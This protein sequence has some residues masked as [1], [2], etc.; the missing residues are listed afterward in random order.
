[1][2]WGGTL[3]R[4]TGMGWAWQWNITSTSQAVNPSGGG[5]APATRT[6]TAVVPVDMPTTETTGDTSILNWIYALQNASFSN[7]VTIASPVFAG[8]NLTLDNKATIS[9]AA[10]K[11]G[12]GGVL[13]MN[14]NADGVGSLLSRI[15]QAYIAGGCAWKGN[16]TPPP[17]HSPCLWDLDNVYA[18]PLHRGSTIPANLITTP[19]LTCCS[20]GGGGFAPSTMGFWYVNASPGPNSPCDAATKTGTPPTFDT[21]DGVINNSATL[22]TPF[23]L[24]PYNASYTCRTSDGQGHTIG[25]LS[26]NA[27]AK[28]LTIKGTIFIDGSATIDKTGYSGNP[29]FTY[30][31]SGAVYLTGTFSEKSTI[32]CSVVS[33]SDC[34]WTAGAWNPNLGSL[35][36]VAYGDGGDGGAEAQGN[37]VRAGDGIDIVSSSFQGALIANKNVSI[38]TTSKDEGPMVSV[39]NS[40]NSG[41]TG[42]MSF[43]SIT[44]APSGAAGVSAPIPPGNLLAPQQ[45]GG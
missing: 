40:V 5:A 29:V 13:S 27:S 30:S 21:G 25:E 44:Q 42:T 18:D 35:V 19:T 45:F 39:Y 2:T 15:G 8:G 9:S 41:Q 1:V 7:Q 20:L 10:G 31:G 22:T 14:Q 11:L 36:I 38:D 17:L 37:V 6:L 23:N 28:V 43:P 12:V 4:V 32:M 26:W 33:G 24:T 34:N 3:T 16:G